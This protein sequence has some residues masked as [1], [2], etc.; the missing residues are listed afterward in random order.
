MNY[1]NDYL[2][3]NN[4]QHPANEIEVDAEI[5]EGWKNLTEAYESGHEHVFKEK[6]IIILNDAYEILYCL[7]SVESGLANRMRLLIN[8]LK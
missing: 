8:K 3:V 4:S 6:Q 5:V 2:G 7:E 1:D